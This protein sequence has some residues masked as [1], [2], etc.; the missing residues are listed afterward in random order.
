MKFIANPDKFIFFIGT[1]VVG[2]LFIFSY[3]ILNQLSVLILLLALWILFSV[4]SVKKTYIE[5]AIQDDKF[6]IRHMRREIEVHFDDINYIV[7][8]LSC[9]NSIKE[10][11]YEIKLNNTLNVPDNLLKI[12]NRTFTKWIEKQKDRFIIEKRVFHGR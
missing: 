6:I 12:E 10:K 2:F 8:S 9:T 11:R 3:M 4:W 1:G 5:Y 7:E